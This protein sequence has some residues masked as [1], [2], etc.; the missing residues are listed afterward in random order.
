[1]DISKTIAEMKKRP[2]FAES[3]GMI[4]TH[5]GVVRNWSRSKPGTISYLEVTADIDKIDRKSVV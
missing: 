3:V 2:D 4:L 1:M 5:N